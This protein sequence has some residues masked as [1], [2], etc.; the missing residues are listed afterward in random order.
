MIFRKSDTQ[1]MK[2]PACAN[3]LTP[4]DAGDVTVDVCQG[5]CAGIWFDL[6]ELKKSQGFT[7]SS[8]RALAHLQKREDLLIDRQAR[9]KCP[10]CDNIVMMRRFF[11]RKRAV[12]IDE[13]PNCGG[14]WLDDGEWQKIRHE[15]EVNER[16]DNGN[17]RDTGEYIR[18]V[19]RFFSDSAV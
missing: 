7:E 17:P 4:F 13:C 10:K 2:C 11:S 8:R 1:H 14:I 12:E 16:H 19:Y 3:E 18:L 5:G 9:R 6:F 15:V